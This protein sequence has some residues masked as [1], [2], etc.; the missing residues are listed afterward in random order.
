M[1][2]GKFQIWLTERGLGM[3]EGWCGDGLTDG[4]LARKMGIAESTLYDWVKR[5]PEISETMRRGRGGAQVQIEN[6][7]FQR[8]KGGFFTVEKP[9]K[10]RR[11]QYDPVT[12]KCVK[13][14][15]YIH[16]ADEEIYVPPDTKAAIFWLSNRA[17]ERWAEKVRLEGDGVLRLEDAL[18]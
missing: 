6:A 7:L 12:G 2:K 9:V 15:E 11:R 13:E 4:E 1:A 3:I 17:P 8:A 18:Q 10:L 16:V 5:Y 14:E